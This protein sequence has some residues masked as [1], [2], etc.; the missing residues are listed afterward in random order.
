[1]VAKV[2]TKTKT[3][4][5]R[6]EAL[7]AG[8]RGLL[9]EQVQLLRKRRS[10][11][12][13]FLTFLSYWHFVSRETGEVLTFGP[14]PEHGDEHPGGLWSGQEEFAKAAIEHPFLYALKAG[15]LG[16]TELGCAYDG[17]IALCG[18]PNARVHLF[19]RDDRASQRLLGY[20]EF[21]L[22]HLPQWLRPTFLVDEAGGRSAHS[23]KFSLGIDDLRAVVSYAAGPNVSVDDTCQH[24][25]VDELAIMQFAE[26]TWSAV[27]STVAPGGSCHVVT[28]GKGE[29]V[30]AAKLW[31]MA[32]AGIS[33]LYPLFVPWAERPGRTL[34][35]YA[36]QEGSLTRQALKHFAPETWEDALAGDDEM[37]FV[38]IELWDRCKEDLPALVEYDGAGNLRV[39]QT[40]IVV[41]L[42]AAV[43]NDSFGIVSGSRHP[44]AERHENTV[45]I[46]GVR[47]WKPPRG[48]QIDLSEPESFLRFLC[49]GGCPSGHARDDKR[50]S[51][52]ACASGITVGAHNV[53]CVTYD[54][55]QLES[56]MQAF[57][58]EGLAP[59]YPFSQ[60][61]ERLIADSELRDLIINRRI[62][63]DGNPYLREHIENSAAKLDPKEDRKIRIVKKAPE[64][65]V[66]LAVATSMMARKCLYLLL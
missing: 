60:Q 17:W 55:Y 41:A 24:A 10:V 6:V 36:I 2:D 63:H 44:D 18:P 25:H 50:D 15:K 52:D 3:K 62:V 54:P 43:T 51:C 46:R 47:E 59:V 20:V 28:R 64:R 33:P 4:T 19:S 65:K 38:P 61:A 14:C 39:D 35:W 42:D 9:L 31:K 56:M 30:F 57:R 40:P 45:V 13:S 16:F 1:M 26:Q 27:Y 37:S 49:L 11:E 21:G 58:K 7:D 29:H 23:L 53:V 48:G 22:S 12:Q 32:Q 8:S 34:E 66:D 5:Q